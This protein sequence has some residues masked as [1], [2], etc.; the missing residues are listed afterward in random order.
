MN[1]FRNW[2]DAQVKRLSLVP[3]EEWNA[4]DHLDA[5]A[6]IDEAYEKAI[7]LRL[8][9]AAC[10]LSDLPIRVRLCELLASL[11][12]DSKPTMPQ[13]DIVLSPPD[14]AGILGCKP[15]TV[16]G[17]IKS[18]ELKASNLASRTS[19][20]PRYAV[21]KSD[22]DTFLAIRRPDL[23]IPRQRRSRLED[24]SRKFY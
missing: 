4:Q 9:G 8:P 1:K 15:D 10:L 18:G 19:T 21:K 3:T 23:P 16:V 6:L 7:E 24:G 5:K 13:D 22:L 17:W 2:L 14:I 12:E 20:R 11:P